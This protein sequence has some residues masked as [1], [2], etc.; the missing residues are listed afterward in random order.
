MAIDLKNILRAQRSDIS[1]RAR[2]LRS[3]VK[4]VLKYGCDFW[5]ITEVA[6]DE[7]LLQKCG[8]SGKCKDCKHTTAVE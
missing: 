6:D 4:P 8:S 2:V 1:I 7:S 3:F 5:T